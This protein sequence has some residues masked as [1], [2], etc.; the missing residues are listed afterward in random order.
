MERGS[1]PLHRSLEADA[2]LVRG[3]ASRS[4]CGRAVSIYSLPG[5]RAARDGRGTTLP[6]HQ[7]S[8]AGSGCSFRKVHLCQGRQWYC[9]LP[10]FRYHLTHIDPACYLPPIGI[11]LGSRPFHSSDTQSCRHLSS[12]PYKKQ[13]RRDLL[14]ELLLQTWGVSLGVPR[15]CVQGSR[16]GMQAGQCQVVVEKELEAE[17]LL[18]PAPRGGEATPLHPHWSAWCGLSLRVQEMLDR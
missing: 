9:L 7:S 3:Q 17:P 16:L 6:P 15:T 8:L 10:I 12:V 4:E 1:R 2:T 13:P 14:S 11:P 18:G 5:G